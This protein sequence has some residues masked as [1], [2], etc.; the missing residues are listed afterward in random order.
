MCRHTLTR[1]RVAGSGVAR[2]AGRSVYTEE[3]YSLRRAGC[4]GA[5]QSTRPLVA[6][7]IRLRS[8]PRSSPP[9]PSALSHPRST[10]PPD[11]LA[12]P[13]TSVVPRATSSRRSRSQGRGQETMLRQPSEAGY[14]GKQQAQQRRATGIG[15]VDMPT[16]PSRR[17]SGHICNSSPSASTSPTVLPPWHSAQRIPSRITRSSSLHTAAAT[18]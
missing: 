5:M 9:S 18:T 2:S 6:R 7:G 13:P 15:Y 10:P 4:G 1:W 8:A 14:G 3:P 17:T 11:L 16:A 12:R